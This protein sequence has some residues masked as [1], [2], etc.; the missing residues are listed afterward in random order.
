VRNMV[1][2]GITESVA[3]RITGHRTREVFE[4]YNIVSEQDLRD[5]AQKMGTVSGTNG[6]TSLAGGERS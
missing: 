1:R 6:R 4:R 3:M 5:A 2:S